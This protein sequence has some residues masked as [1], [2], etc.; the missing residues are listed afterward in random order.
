[1]ANSPEAI[2]QLRA[3]NSILKNLTKKPSKPK[4]PTQAQVQTNNTKTKARS[5]VLPQKATPTPSSSDSGSSPSHESKEATVESKGK[6]SLE[7]V[8]EKTSKI[9]GFMGSWF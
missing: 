9:R 2:A 1:L 5:K 8:K 3:A 4:N 7:E 6:P